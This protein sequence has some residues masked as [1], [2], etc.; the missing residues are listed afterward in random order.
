LGGSGGMMP[1]SGLE[2][3]LG[4]NMILHQESLVSS[5]G[6]VISI[7]VVDNIFGKRF[8]AYLPQSKT[9]RKMA[10]DGRKY[11]SLNEFTL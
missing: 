11:W 10:S 5:L 9:N 2:T 3:H 1:P 8:S 4:A 6:L 7:S